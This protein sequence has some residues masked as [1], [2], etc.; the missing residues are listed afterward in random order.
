MSPIVLGFFALGLAGLAA[1]IT[2]LWLNLRGAPPGGDAARWRAA[3][4]AA[5]A[6]GLV[7]GGV[8]IPLTFQLGYPVETWE[9]HGHVVG[10]PFFVAYTDWSGQD[11]LSVLSFADVAGNSVFW[12][13]VPQLALWLWAAR[14][15][16][17]A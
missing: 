8:S 12:F 7:L 5:F 4:T 17:R 16:L 14:R 13:L 2:A 10:V 3:R 6:I 15:R 9:G 1:G 11:Y